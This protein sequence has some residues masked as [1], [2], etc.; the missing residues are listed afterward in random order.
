MAWQPSRRAID[1]LAGVGNG[2]SLRD[3]TCMLSSPSQPG[4]WQR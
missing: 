1:R 2:C 3:F 4:R